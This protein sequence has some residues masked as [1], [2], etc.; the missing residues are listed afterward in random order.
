MAKNMGTLDRLIR[1]LVVAPAAAV[2]AIAL[3]AGT[4][5]GVV[6]LIV[7]AIMLATALVGWCPLYTL[8]RVTTRAARS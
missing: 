1:G 4:P 6:L 3:G 8:F 5:A 7:A 2:G